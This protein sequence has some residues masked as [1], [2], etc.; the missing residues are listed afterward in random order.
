M[1]TRGCVLVRTCVY[2][3]K[4]HCVGGR[5]ETCGALRGAGETRGGDHGEKTEWRGVRE[6]TP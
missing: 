1:C 5:E 6:G 3:I 4:C 2:M